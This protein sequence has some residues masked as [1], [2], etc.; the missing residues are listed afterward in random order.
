MGLFLVAAWRALQ[1]FSG[2]RVPCRDRCRPNR[3][4]SAIGAHAHPTIGGSFSSSAPEP[5]ADHAALAPPAYF[6]SHDEPQPD[7]VYGRLER[8][9]VG[10]RDRL[11]EPAEPRRT[12][13]KPPAQC[14]PERSYRRDSASNDF[15]SC[16]SPYLAFGSISLGST[17][18][19]PSE[20]RDRS[21]PSPVS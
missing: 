6:A 7:Q 9:G 5:R 17:A 4:R 10:N 18:S 12:S 3:V 16:S 11:P 21:A 2:G 8:P 1:S 15:A 19:R 14:S 13:A 20:W